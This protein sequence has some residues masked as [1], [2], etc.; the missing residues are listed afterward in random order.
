[1]TI[2][3]LAFNFYLVYVGHV[4]TTRTKEAQGVY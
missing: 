4:H 2:T 3:D 1:M